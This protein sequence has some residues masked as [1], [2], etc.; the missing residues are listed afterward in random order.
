MV[1]NNLLTVFFLTFL[2]GIL[3]ANGETPTANDLADGLAAI[4][5]Q[6][7]N[8]IYSISVIK[9]GVTDTRYFERS[10]R[11]HNCYSVA[12][13]FTVTAIGILQDRGL[14]TTD[15]RVCSILGNQFPQDFDPKW[16][17]VRIRDVLTHRIGFENGFLDIDTENMRSWASEDFLGLVLS[18]P[19]KYEPGTEFTYSD[20]A[21]YL[22]SRIFTAKSGE[23]LDDFLI[24]EIANPLEFAEFAFSKCPEGYPM[25]ATGLYISTEDMAK[26][27][28]LYVQ[29]GNWEG[30]QILSEQFVEQAFR[31]RFELYR[32]EGSEDAFCKGGMNGQYLYMNRKTGTVCAIHTFLGNIEKLKDFLLK[33]DH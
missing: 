7:E 3:M 23:A 4:A 5:R 8:S 6:D 13:L 9:D 16:K 1:K 14:L 22:A 26:L 24:R 30:K 21:F 2:S 20:A 12:K 29:K 10:T 28:K 18:H 31:D 15:D 33:N 27:G 17:D 25:G 19:L 32:I 11:C